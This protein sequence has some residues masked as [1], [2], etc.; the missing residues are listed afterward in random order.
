MNGREGR[1][2]EHT[3]FNKLVETDSEVHHSG[4]TISKM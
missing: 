2:R 3:I 4:V 1:I